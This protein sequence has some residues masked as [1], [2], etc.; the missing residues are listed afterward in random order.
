[1]VSRK[2]DEIKD[3]LSN[4]VKSKDQT[5]LTEE[6]KN[7]SKDVFNLM[8]DI[9]ASLDETVLGKM[10]EVIKLLCGC[11]KTINFEV[12]LRLIKSALILIR[13][14]IKPEARIQELLD[15]AK[16]ILD[17]RRKSN[18]PKMNEDE[19]HQWWILMKKIIKLIKKVDIEPT[20]TKAIP[21]AN[22][23]VDCGEWFVAKNDHPKAIEIL[24]RAIDA[25]DLSCGEN[26]KSYFI[27][28]KCCLILTDAY[29]QSQQLNEANKWFKKTEKAFKQVV[30]FPEDKEEMAKFYEL[31][32]TL[33]REF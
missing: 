8:K 7:A 14:I 22:L 32:L 15:F 4:F 16:L 20:K 10:K 31:L 23:S 26:N 19:F 2:L 17:E 12:T 6:L 33:R 13:K 29:F 18:T 11:K 30:N 28:T 27:Y 24:E 25:L 9:D 3:E 1:M 5:N 21:A